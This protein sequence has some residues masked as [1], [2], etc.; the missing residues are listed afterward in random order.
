MFTSITGPIECPAVLGGTI[1]VTE[2]QNITCTITNEGEGFLK[3]VK[4][5][6]LNEGVDDFDFR[7]MIF[8][9]ANPVRDELLVIEPT[10]S[11]DQTGFI[12]VLP[13]NNWKIEEE[14]LPPGFRL[15]SA[16]CDNG[17]GTL[18]LNTNTISDIIVNQGDRVICTF[19]NVPSGT[20]I[21]KKITDQSLDPT[22]FTFTGYLVG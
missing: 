16:S 1:T 5:N 20:I 7:F 8:E 22:L 14:E 21:V 2:G 9:G 11:T 4:K 15:L 10:K 19:E 6:P 17:S 13:A 18:D 12:S 3:I